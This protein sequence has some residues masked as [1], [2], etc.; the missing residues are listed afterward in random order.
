MHFI[1]QIAFFTSFSDPME[2]NL[3]L[4]KFGFNPEKDGNL[5]IA[6]SN[7]LRTLYPSEQISYTMQ[8]VVIRRFQLFS[9][10]NILTDTTIIIKN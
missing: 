7:F 3:N 8:N 5:L 9:S 10:S 2:A 4:D 6:I 1:S